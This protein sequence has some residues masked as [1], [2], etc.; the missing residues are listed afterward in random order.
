MGENLNLVL[1]IFLSFLSFVNK[2]V[3]ITPIGGIKEK[4]WLLSKNVLSVEI[5]GSLW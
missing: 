2:Y 4:I 5:A 1:S 3:L